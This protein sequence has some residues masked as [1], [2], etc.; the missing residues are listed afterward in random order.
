MQ[1]IGNSGGV[2]TPNAQD[3]LV[4]ITPEP[5]TLALV[6]I[7]ALPLLPIVRRRRTVV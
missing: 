2:D 4:E 7:G 6:A 3:H 1:L 5:A